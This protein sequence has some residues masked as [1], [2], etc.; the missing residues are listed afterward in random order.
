MFLLVHDLCNENCK[1]TYYRVN[2]VLF[3]KYLSFKS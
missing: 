3:K 1:A 2:I